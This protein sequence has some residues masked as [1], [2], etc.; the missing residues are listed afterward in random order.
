M[1]IALRK[2][3]HHLVLHIKLCTHK[4]NLIEQYKVTVV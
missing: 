2:Q 1:V 4:Y 3:T